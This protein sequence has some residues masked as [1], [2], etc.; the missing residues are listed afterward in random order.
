VVAI[1]DEHEERQPRGEPRAGKCGQR[2][3]QSGQRS[4][5]GRGARH[6]R[7]VVQESIV[8]IEALATSA[9]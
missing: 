3:P 7:I 8:K 6:V 5:R 4:N 9:Q 2:Q 1:Q